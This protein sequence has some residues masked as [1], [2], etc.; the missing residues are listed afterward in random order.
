MEMAKNNNNKIDS[1]SVA[2]KQN[3][4]NV[5]KG[6]KQ[7]NF[8]GG[9]KQS[10]LLHLPEEVHTLAKKDLEKIFANFSDMDPKKRELTLRKYFTI[11]IMVSM[12][13]THYN[14]KE[15]KFERLNKTDLMESFLK[16][17]SSQLEDDFG[18]VRDRSRKKDKSE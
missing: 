18:Y 16:V 8:W 6:I 5:F 4:L 2:W 12:G 10:Y 1:N 17:H 14:D 3:F 15:K 9:S 13:M 7:W 11:H